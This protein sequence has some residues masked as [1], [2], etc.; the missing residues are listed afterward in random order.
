VKFFSPWM[1]WTWYAVEFDGKD[2]FFGLVEGF[3]TEWGY[4]V[5]PGTVPDVSHRRVEEP[6]G[7]QR[8]SAVSNS[9]AVVKSVAEVL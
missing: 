7:A 2:I 3:A 4:F 6:A 9:A 5:V 1:N 8:D